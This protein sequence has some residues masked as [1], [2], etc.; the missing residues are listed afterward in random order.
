MAQY[1]ILD[2]Y[3][4]IFQRKYQQHVLVETSKAFV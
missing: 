3:H 1:A 4:K 2:K